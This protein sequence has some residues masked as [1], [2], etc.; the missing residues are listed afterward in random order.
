M[1]FFV[2]PEDGED[3]IE[4]GAARGITSM[5]MDEKTRKLYKG[6]FKKTLFQLI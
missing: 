2:A 4:N 3:I 6:V 1:R 5:D